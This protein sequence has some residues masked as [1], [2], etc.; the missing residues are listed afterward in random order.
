MLEA[1]AI[2][3]K[4][5]VVTDIIHFNLLREKLL[6]SDWQKEIIFQADLKYLRNT[7]RSFQLL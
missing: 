5:M 2:D 6:H 3:I 4:A 7:M 1:T